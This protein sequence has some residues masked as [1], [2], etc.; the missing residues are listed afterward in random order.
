M[1]QFR[2]RAWVLRDQFGDALKGIRS[3]EELLGGAI[4]VEATVT[5]TVPPARVF[6]M[7]RDY[8]YVK[9]DPN[10]TSGESTQPTETAQDAPEAQGDT[11]TPDKVEKPVSTD[12]G[13]EKTP[14]QALADLV[15]GEGYTFDQWQAWALEAGFIDEEVGSFDEVPVVKASR[16]IG[17][18]RGMLAQLKV[19]TAGK[20]K[21]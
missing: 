3:T 11:K 7:D 19:Y 6:Q 14:Q 10:G 5:P 21:A 12:P 16:A 20:G 18:K 1:L 8:A 2:A 15:I 17:S 4:D 13:A 9:G